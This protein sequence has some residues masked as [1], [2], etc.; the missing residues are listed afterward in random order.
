MA[1]IRISDLPS[2]ASPV[3]TEVVAIDGATT[4]KATIAAI[5]NAAH[6]LASQAEAEAGTEAAKVMTPLTT[7]QA[8][9]E[10]ALTKS[11]N[12][13]GLTDASAA[14]ANLGL[15]IGTNVQA[16]DAGLNSIAGLTVPAARMLYTTAEDTWAATSLFAVGRTFLAAS[17]AEA[18]RSALGL[19]TAALEDATSFA[20][21]VEDRTALLALSPVNGAVVNVKD[22]ARGGFFD[23]STAD[24][25]ANVTADPGAIKVVPFTADPT[26]ASG[27]HIW[28]KMWRFNPRRAG[29]FGDINGDNTSPDDWVALQRSFD[30]ASAEGAILEIDRPYRFG[31]DNIGKAGG[32]GQLYTPSNLYVEGLA[33]GL[34]IPVGYSSSGS[35]ITNLITSSSAL[36]IVSNVRFSNVRGD[37]TDYDP[38]VLKGTLAAGSSGGGTLPALPTYGTLSSVDGIYNDLI[39]QIVDGPGAPDYAFVKN[40]NGTAKTFTIL[41]PGGGT[42]WDVTPDNTSLFELGFN[43]NLFGFSGGFSDGRFF[44]CEA[45]NVP[46]GILGAGGK[47]FNA[48]SGVE[49]VIVDRFVGRTI[50]GALLFTQGHAGTSGNGAQKWVKNVTF[51]NCKGSDCGALIAVLGQDSST[52]PD[53]DPDDNMVR[54]INTHGERCGHMDQRVST[55]KAKSAA[56]VIEE[57]GNF[58]IRDTVIDNDSY[59]P[60]YTTDTYRVGY[61]LTGYPDAIR[62]WGRNGE[63]LNTFLYGNFNSLHRLER[64]RAFGG[65]AGPTGKPQNTY[66]IN[67]KTIHHQGTLDTNP[68]SV[69]SDS[70]LRPDAIEVRIVYDDIRVNSDPTAMFDTN[71]STYTGILIRNAH[72][73][74]QSKTVQKELTATQF[75]SYGNTI[76]TAALGAGRKTSVTIA[77]DTVVDITPPF[78][79]GIFNFRIKEGASV[80]GGVAGRVQYSVSSSAQC[81]SLGSGANVVVGTTALTTDS[82]TGTDVKLNIAAVLATGHIQ[83]K[84]RMGASRDWEYWFE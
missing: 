52:D 33:D 9:T 68:F 43:D 27:A 55:S 46:L 78:S 70:S 75:I 15:V 22:E 82:V 62:G 74:F 38:F 30:W 60:T 81:E 58:L 34:L 3:S 39:I 6:P 66:R 51:Q 49:N 63:V 19:G 25:S 7:K 23:T 61:G 35:I 24:E 17:T 73:W 79:P 50:G 28:R 10:Q 54:F 2:E 31:N 42:T 65:D 36:S 26:G 71:M 4:R 45:Y 69:S 11:G 8:I 13:T 48:E 77:D 20:T 37:M 59:T 67:F 56:I 72:D 12:L 47:G 64:N 18:Q 83:M 53:G 44:D 80:S 41:K 57:A 1:D 40:Y 21:N 5:V 84:N 16:Y 29:A 14:R 76:A 32:Y